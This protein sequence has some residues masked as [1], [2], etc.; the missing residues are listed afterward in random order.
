[1]T[2][3]AVTYLTA[4]EAA[5]Y[6]RIHRTT[7]NKYA[8]SGRVQASK[9]AGRWLFEQDDLDAFVRGGSNTVEAPTRRK[10]RRA[11]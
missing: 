6:L 7:L 8:N 10:R 5:A 3:P 11:S 4:P 9:P 2:A 1:M